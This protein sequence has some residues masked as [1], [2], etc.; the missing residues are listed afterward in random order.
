[1]AKALTGKLCA[2]A[3]LLAML[4]LLLKRGTEGWSAMLGA[5]LALAALVWFGV[6]PV[7]AAAQQQPVREAA[8]R[9]RELDLPVVSYRTFLPSFSVYRGAVTP[10]RAP[11]PGE[12]V[13]VRLDRLEALQR[14]LGP[15]VVLIPEFQKGG[16]ALLLRPALPAASAHGPERQPS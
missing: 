12:L 7:L 11:L 9:A 15:Q 10:N 2:A 4:V 6:V 16:V 1:M 8:L 5:A 14:E 3:A 13:F